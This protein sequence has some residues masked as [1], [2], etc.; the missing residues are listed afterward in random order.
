MKQIFSVFAIY[1]KCTVFL[2]KMQ[3]VSALFCIQ[4]GYSKVKI[5]KYNILKINIIKNMNAL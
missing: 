1:L 3:Q 4:N 2:K 5:N